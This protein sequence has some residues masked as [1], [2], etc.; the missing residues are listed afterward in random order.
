MNELKGFD[1][2][3]EALKIFRKYGNPIYPT[4]CQHD[5]LMV[6]ID[7]SIVSQKDIEKLK[8]LSFIVSEED[9]EDCFI[10]FHFGSA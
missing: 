8:K 1:V 5:V 4:Q 2:L 10:S 3:I 9:G 7:P 6:G